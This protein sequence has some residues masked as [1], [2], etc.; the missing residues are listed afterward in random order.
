VNVRSEEN[1]WS[2][3]YEQIRSNRE[4]TEEDLRDDHG[5]GRYDLDDGTTEREGEGVDLIPLRGH[6]ALS[7]SHDCV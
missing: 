2:S 6:V 7:R 5:H 1:A 3:G 4:A